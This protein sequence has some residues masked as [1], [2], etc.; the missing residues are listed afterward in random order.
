MDYSKTSFRTAGELL[1]NVGSF[2]HV[3]VLLNR[4]DS[5]QQL[6]GG[7][8]PTSKMPIGIYT[9]PM[10]GDLL[11]NAHVASVVPFWPVYLPSPR[12]LQAALGVEADSCTCPQVCSKPH[13]DAFGKVSGTALQFQC[14]CRR[15]KIPKPKTAKARLS[16]Q[17]DGNPELAAYLTARPLLVNSLL[18]SRVNEAR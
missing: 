18:F 4:G 8:E 16:D 6:F 3:S 13:A 1:Y 12:G 5:V 7:V 11:Q 14:T 15:S 10:T 9:S 17:Y 2:S